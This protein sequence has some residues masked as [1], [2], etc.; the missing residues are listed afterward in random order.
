MSELTLIPTE[1]QVA[2]APRNTRVR[3][4]GW[5][6]LVH[7][8]RFR[9]RTQVTSLVRKA[10]AS[11]GSYG[12]GAVWTLGIFLLGYLIGTIEGTIVANKLGAQ[13]D[14]EHVRFLIWR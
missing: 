14:L 10:L 9:E 13:V 3:R 12:Q 4:F 5:R 11:T 6:V 7:L 2:N 1:P 8:N